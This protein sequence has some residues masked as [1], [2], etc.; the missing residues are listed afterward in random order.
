MLARTTTGRLLPLAICLAALGCSD[1][2]KVE[3]PKAKSGQ[4]APA[5]TGQQT[6]TTPAKPALEA[7]KS[8]LV[9]GG[10]N[11]ATQAAD[12]LTKLAQQVMPE[13][14]PLQAMMGPV[15]QQEFKLKSAAVLDLNAPIRFAILDRKTYG[16]APEALMVGITTPKAFADA[17]PTTGKKANVDGNAWTYL[18]YEGARQPVFVNFAGKLAVITRNKDI[19]PKHKEFFTAL[20]AAKLPETGAVMVEMEHLMA[21]RGN[22]FKRNLASLRKTL[23]QAGDA[24]KMG[25]QM[26]AA[27]K[28]IDWIEKSAPEV[29]TGA[30]YLVT[31]PDGLKLDFRINPKAD[32]KLSTTL[33][34]FKGAGRT[35][36]LAK[37]PAN[38]PAFMTFDFQPDQAL[39][40]F[41]AL[42]KAFA[43]DPIFK[44]DAAKAKPYVDAMNQ[45]VKGMDGQMT[46]GTLPGATGMELATMFGVTDA[47]ALRS[48]QATMSGM[49]TD[50]AAQ[51]YYDQMGIKMQLQQKAYTVGGVP[52]DIVRTTMTNLP[53]EAAGMI[54]IMGD[55]FVQHIAIGDTMGVMAYGESGKTRVEAML[56]GKIAGGLDKNPAV[57]R[58]IKEAAPNFSL[59]GWVNPIELAKGVKLGGMNPLAALLA[60][61]KSTS[62]LGISAGVNG[63]AAQMVIDIPVALVKD[64]FAAFQKTKG[65]F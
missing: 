64:G 46:M 21:A 18:K 19:F 40:T 26:D 29:D 1:K 58:A 38:A 13:V 4:T 51:A 47:K 43:I 25:G 12:A 9:Y 35:A 62:G 10:L 33:A 52:V 15:L 28:M 49:Y 36:L 57:Q 42:S 5:S 61:I 23:A 3:D 24:A 31:R 2:K 56:N 45:Y 32:S 65:G 11:N 54:G 48:A 37:L 53:P 60:D 44:G 59:L 16:R 6:P 7:P 14:P 20:G 22:L 30:I 34:A 41:G 55:F 27:N 50:P 8:V 63:G 17:L 39:K